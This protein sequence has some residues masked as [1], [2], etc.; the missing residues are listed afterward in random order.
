MVTVGIFIYLEK[1]ISQISGQVSRKIFNDIHFLPINKS[2]VCTYLSLIWAWLQ[3][4]TIISFTARLSFLIHRKMQFCNYHNFLA[5]LQKN[6][7]AFTR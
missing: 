7:V 5:D 4:Q 6:L 3:E 1:T 2:K